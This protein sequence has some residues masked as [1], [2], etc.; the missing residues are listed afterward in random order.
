M[1]PEEYA[2]QIAEFIRRK[3]V[4]RCPTACALP[5]QG[6]VSAADRAALRRYAN[7][8]EMRHERSTRH[9]FAAP[10]AAGAGGRRA[11]AARR[12]TE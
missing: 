2:T 6:T 7:A 5:T 1:S 10:V 3:G 12:A 8:C 4:T 11:Q 9:P